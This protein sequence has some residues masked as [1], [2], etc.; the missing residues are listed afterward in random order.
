MAYGTVPFLD[1]V[2]VSVSR[3]LVWDIEAFKN[4]IHFRPEVRPCYFGFM[5]IEPL[6]GAEDLHSTANK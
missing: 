1:F 6:F 5:D 2:L 3:T 4:K